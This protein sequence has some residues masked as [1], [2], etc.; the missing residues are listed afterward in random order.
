MVIFQI[1]N[2]TKQT[3]SQKTWTLYGQALKI[4]QLQYALE[5]IIHISTCHTF[6]KNTLFTNKH[7][8]HTN[9]VP[10]RQ[11]HRINVRN[12]TK[13]RGFPC[14]S[15][16]MSRLFKCVMPRCCLNCCLISF[17][18][19]MQPLCWRSWFRPFVH[20]ATYTIG[21]VFETLQQ[22]FST[23]SSRWCLRRVALK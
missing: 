20:R 6:S 21:D 14:I 15:S 7:I 23:N 2:S 5:L 13:L 10:L 19:A 17:P 22:T 8:P 9:P 3:L 4:Q 16:N 18:Y 12:M 11:S 1:R